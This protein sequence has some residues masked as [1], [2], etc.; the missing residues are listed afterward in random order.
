MG[1][2]F[3]AWNSAKNCF[4]SYTF[5]IGQ[6]SNCLFSLYELTETWENV[7]VWCENVNCVSSLIENSEIE[8]SKKRYI[9]VRVEYVIV[10]IENDIWTSVLFKCCN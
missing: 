4:V 7:L 9:Y 2:V 8:L 10:K 1:E 3:S 6:C 5:N